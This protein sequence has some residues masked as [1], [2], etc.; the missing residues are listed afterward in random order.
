[1]IGCFFI[2]DRQST[3][4]DGDENFDLLPLLMRMWY[5]SM[6][7]TTG[8]SL[9][10]APCCSYGRES[11]ALVPCISWIKEKPRT[12]TYLV[13]FTCNGIP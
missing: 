7:W 2:I 6:F 10:N 9:C 3:F 1:M 12:K 11:S 5:S 4:L 13:E 8:I